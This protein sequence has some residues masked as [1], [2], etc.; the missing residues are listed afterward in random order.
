MLHIHTYR[1]LH[2][3]L[4]KLIFSHVYRGQH[5]VDDREPTTEIALA[6][7]VSRSNCS[8][9]LFISPPR[10][11]LPFEPCSQSDTQHRGGHGDDPLQ[12]RFSDAIPRILLFGSV[13]L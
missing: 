13:C 5:R 10:P 3:L 9:P 2:I 4:S 7:S 1:L 6:Q 11:K 12:G 8:I